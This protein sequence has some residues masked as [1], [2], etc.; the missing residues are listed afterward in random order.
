[1]CGFIW[2]TDHIFIQL[3]FKSAKKI[4]RVDPIWL[5]S[6]GYVQASMRNLLGVG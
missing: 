2:I 4:C 6:Q 3:M 5:I 1:M